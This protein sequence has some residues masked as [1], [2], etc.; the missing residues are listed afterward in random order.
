MLR[1]LEPIDNYRSLSK[2]YWPSE[3][4]LGRRSVI[5]G[6]NGSGKS[7]FASLLLEIATD[8]TSTEVVWE[9]EF[10]QEH[11]VR[12]G[13]GGPSPALAVFTKEWVQR[14]LSQFL[15]G[16]T[17]SPIVTL[18]EEAIEAKEQEQELVRLI[19][20]QRANAKEAEQK[21]DGHAGKARK[22]AATAQDAI[23]GQLREFDY[24]RFSKNRFSMPTVEG[25]LRV[26]KGE[27]P[28]ENKHAE[29]L[30]R[31]GEGA[32]ERVGTISDP[33]KSDSIALDGLVALLAE[34]PSRVA[35][36]ALAADK[37]GQ[38]WV[39]RGVQLHEHLDECLFC[40]GPIS[41]E[42]REQLANHFDR[43]WLEIRGRAQSLLQ[44]VRQ[45]K[46]ALSNWLREVPEPRSLSSELRDG[47]AVHVAAVND[48]IS[49]R[50]AALEAIERVLDSKAD[51]PS[52]TPQMP[53]GAVLNTDFSAASL[54]QAVAEHNQQA[55]EHAVVVE[56]RYEIV[57]DHVIGS[58]SEAFRTAESQSQAAQAD[59]KAANEA[60]DLAQRTL[61]AI[62]ERQFSNSQMAETLTK[63]L[64]RVYGKNHLSVAVTE[65]G[66]SYACRRGGAPATHLSDGERTTL[67]L[68]YFLRKLE[69]ESTS[70]DQAARVVVIDDP[71]SS[72]DREA[73][74]ATH[75]WLVDS[76]KGFGQFIVLTHDFGLLRL[77][78]KSQ[79]N[80][81]KD[82]RR[83][84]SR[85]G[86]VNEERFPK[87]AFLEMYATAGEGGRCTKV[88]ALPP[89]LLQHTT[90]YAYLFRQVMDGVVNGT[91]HDRLFLLPNAA[92]RVLE[93]FTSYKAPH[94]GNF[95]QRLESLMGDDASN[96]YRDVY[97]F[98]N[99]FSHGEGSESIDVLDGRVVHG[100][101]R[102]CMEFFKFADTEHFERM[103]KATGAD[104]VAVT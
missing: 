66:K 100:Q 43:S 86:D 24:Q 17:A 72:L 26:Y 33:P 2:G 51:D 39:E 27:F 55:D 36:E 13:E 102:R 50:L 49:V 9:D 101:I 85:E 88:A 73:L 3:L 15:D 70:G 68:L 83:R 92:R 104:P 40:A 97:D 38:E 10:G 61:T 6:H 58:R 67:S 76:L 12:V 84:R 30:K 53:D 8:G 22:L 78:L 99:R 47:Y 25:R 77:F 96:P 94:L 80:A 79:K 5:Y 69:D 45:A 34:T 87:V 81:W 42:R 91:D 11:A 54:Q 44:Q 29:A 41:A 93:V 89:M 19:E 90:E 48:Q 65:D 64:A 32:A 7:S 14:N 46:L 37:S 28:D 95:D 82:S 71:S 62:R 21:R 18:G 60:A 63:D 103:C 23:A 1:R 57:L 59:V 52:V 35:L 98:C 56:G 4:P 16:A 20:E 75:Q 31:L 74:F